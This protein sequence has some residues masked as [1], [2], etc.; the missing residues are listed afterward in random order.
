MIAILLIILIA[1]WPPFFIF[2]IVS[3]SNKKK[4]QK[5]VSAKLVDKLL[6]TKEQA[7][8]T[9]YSV[10]L[11]GS[12]RSHYTYQE[13]PMFYI[14]TFDVEYQD[15]SKGTI[16]CLHDSETCKNLTAKTVKKQRKSNK[17]KEKVNA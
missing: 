11:D 14:C 9:G 8:N 1:L 13:V 15:G 3:E 17:I 2:L 12:Y 5:V 6:I 4:S 16:R 7:K 10:G